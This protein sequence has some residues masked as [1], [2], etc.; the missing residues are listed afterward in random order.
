M[1]KSDRRSK[2]KIAKVKNKKLN[3]CSNYKRQ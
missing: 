3:D 1:R 2:K